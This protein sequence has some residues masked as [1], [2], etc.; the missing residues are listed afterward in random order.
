MH[1]DLSGH[2][3]ELIGNF[4]QHG[5]PH[6]MKLCEVYKIMIQATVNAAIGLLS[7]VASGAVG[8]FLFQ[9]GKGLG[10]LTP[11][12][13]D[14][15]GGNPIDISGTPRLNGDPIGLRDGPKVNFGLYQWGTA[16]LTGLTVGN[17]QTLAAAHGRQNY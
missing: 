16:T 17:W 13:G 4:T 15:V 6:G 7:T 3:I 10:K 9:P 14:P 2:I 11:I 1:V 12:V 5:D 8:L